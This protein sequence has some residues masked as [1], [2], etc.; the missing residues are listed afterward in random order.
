MAAS[1]TLNVIA[2]VSGG[3]DSF[4]S[5]LHCL[6]NGHRIVALANLHPPAEATGSAAPAQSEAHG[7]QQRCSPARAD[8]DDGP[9]HSQHDNDEVDLNSFMYQTVGHQVIPLYA[10]ATGLPLFRQPI[11]G[12]AV[13]HGI[14]YHDPQASPAPARA[15]GAGR[16]PSDSAPRP[17]GDG[18]VVAGRRRSTGDED[19]DEQEDETESL[20]PLLRAVMAAHPEANALCSG[21]I[22]STYQRT[23]VES[24]ALRL[25]LVPLGFLWQFPVLPT[26]TLPASAAAT[27]TA[28]AGQVAAL[29]GSQASGRGAAEDDDDGAQ[30]LLDMAAVGLEAR[31]VKVA[32][33]GLEEDFLWRNVADADSVRSV[34]RALRRFGWGVRGSVLGE[35]GE[36]ETLVVNGPPALFKGRIVV[37]DSDRRVV[38][39]GGGSTWLSIRE[40]KVEM[41][42]DVEQN[43]SAVGVRIPPLLDLRFESVLSDLLENTSSKY[44][45]QEC[46]ASHIKGLQQ[47]AS[48]ASSQQWRF[49]GSGQEL[50]VEEQT[51]SVVQEI[52]GL[53]DPRAIT[54]TVIILRRMSDFGS[55][56]K[57]YGALF[58]EPNPPARV[59][60][61]CGDLLPEGSK[62]AVYLMVQPHLTPS[63]RQGLHVQSRSYWAPANI[64]PYS[65]AIAYPFQ[66]STEATSIRTQSTQSPGTVTIAGQ[67]SLIPASMEL[68]PPDAT[69]Q[70]I[71]LALQ[72]LWRVGVEMRTQWW[73]SA[74]AYFPRTASAGDMQEKARLAS[75]A[76]QQAHVWSV[77]GDEEEDEN[78]PDL[79]DRKYNPMYISLAG[80]DEASDTP[81]LPNWEVFPEYDP[82]EKNQL[83]I[84]YAFSAEVEELPRGAGVE[85]HAHLGLVRINP[86]SVSITTAKTRLAEHSAS[87]ELHHAIVDSDDDVFVHTTAVLSGDD[88][89]SPLE[90]GELGRDIA[91]KV[92]T[93]VQAVVESEPHSDPVSVW[94]YLCYVDAQSVSYA[95]HMSGAGQTPKPEA[96]IPCHSLWGH[97]ENRLHVVAVFQ[98]HY[99]RKP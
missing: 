44:E 81:V 39:E 53:L 19:E 89:G 76:W 45:A 63:T 91:S 74:V 85:W 28:A 97:D 87:L 99:S 93:S 52:Q 47:D 69:A 49:V 8:H 62:I 32:S 11:T 90:L 1:Q 35:G 41:K 96:I 3:K 7:P 36:F 40:A 38:S 50:S 86:G 80:S 29:G 30:L 21:A 65:Q 26:W 55:I 83:P 14:S 82:D 66:G 75:Q 9:S 4:F 77:G 48:Q 59:T 34:K 25:G 94:P 79:W 70:Q 98:Q 51:A 10:A 64:G 33:A 42:T 5:A 23:R 13:Q 58:T 12:T 95:N 68:P 92:Q 71:T 18:V 54:N 57:L 15:V 84:P 17:P 78:G 43:D 67:I 56:N 22:L 20:V 24:V 46:A 37:Q 88:G 2:L 27:K 73:T 72:H 31:I 6:A 61:S 60:I 16:V